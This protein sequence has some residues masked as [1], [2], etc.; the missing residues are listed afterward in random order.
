MHLNPIARKVIDASKLANF[1]TEKFLLPVKPI[2]TQRY[3]TLRHTPTREILHPATGRLLTFVPG[4]IDLQL[5]KADMVVARTD[6]D[7]TLKD[8]PKLSELLDTLALSEPL[9]MGHAPNPQSVHRAYPV[10]SRSGVEY[11]NVDYKAQP[12]YAEYFSKKDKDLKSSNLGDLRP[13][14]LA[15]LYK[16]GREQLQSDYSLGGQDRPPPDMLWTPEEFIKYLKTGVVPAGQD[17]CIDFIKRCLIALA[18]YEAPDSPQLQAF[19]FDLG[20]ATQPQQVVELAVAYFQPVEQ[21]YLSFAAPPPAQDDDWDT[22]WN[23]NWVD[24]TP[25]TI[26][27]SANYKAFATA[28]GARSEVFEAIASALQKDN[29]IFDAIFSSPDE[30]AWGTTFFSKLG[31][32]LEGCTGSQG[33]AGVL[34][35]KNTYPGGITHVSTMG[36]SADGKVSISHHESIAIVDKP[37]MQ[38]GLAIGTL[39][40]PSATYNTIEL[41]NRLQARKSGN[42]MKL[43]DLPIYKSFTDSGAPMV[44]FTP[45]DDFPAFEAFNVRVAAQGQYTLGPQ[46]LYGVDPNQKLAD[47]AAALKAGKLQLTPLKLGMLRANRAMALHP[48]LPPPGATGEH[49]PGLYTNNCGRLTLLALLA[50][51]APAL[52]GVVYS[53]AMDLTDV[54]TLLFRAG[55]MPNTDPNVLRLMRDVGFFYNKETHTVDRHT[56][57]FLALGQLTGWSNAAPGTAGA[58]EPSVNRRP[59]KQPEVEAEIRKKATDRLIDM[60][61]KNQQTFLDTLGP[62]PPAP[63]LP[64]VVRELSIVGQRALIMSHLSGLSPD[65]LHLRFGVRSAEAAMGNLEQKAQEGHFGVFDP[66]GKTMVGLGVYTYLVDG[67]VPAVDVGLSVLPAY[68]KKGVAKGAMHWAMC[69]AR[70]RGMVRLSV[71]YKTVNTAVRDLLLSL[72]QPVAKDTLDGTQLAEI[73]LPAADGQ[74]HLLEAT[75]LHLSSA[76][77]AHT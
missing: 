60:V 65:D 11:L 13:A 56:A 39:G 73:T 45:L 2:Q 26:S 12:W 43:V 49:V 46:W 3:I 57:E 19:L 67:D 50:G 1:K 18:R 66:T 70:N 31:Q 14:H 23:G 44:T 22:M 27:R 74:S 76:W 15:L 29:S 52:R 5:S 37:G 36:F 77:P 7:P 53:E 42:E 38:D 33:V 20:A 24:K 35:F 16:I 6:F 51:R 30:I 62:N 25:S 8:H 54:A 28:F 59:P 63:S 40:I 32:M 9:T 55:L 4:H 17:N 72:G 68:R 47:L 34:Y 41:H 21:G 48:K 71:E 58:Y 69:R 61:K 64:W 75:H 10:M